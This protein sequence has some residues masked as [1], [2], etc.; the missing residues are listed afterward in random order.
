MVKKPIREFELRNVKAD[1]FINQAKGLRLVKK[2]KRQEKKLLNK[3]KFKSRTKR[4]HF[5]MPII[6]K[7]PQIQRGFDITE[8]WKDENET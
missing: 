7:T 8:K 3:S 1:D 6:H 2:R 4:I 5:N